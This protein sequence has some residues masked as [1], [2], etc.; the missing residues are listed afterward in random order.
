M[1]ETT[2]SPSNTISVAVLFDGGFFLKRHPRVYSASIQSGRQ[3][4]ENLYRMALAHADKKYLYRIFYY[5]CLPFEKRIHHP[6]TNRLIDFSKSSIAT[7]R[8]EVIDELKKKR[9]VALRISKL[10][11]KR[12]WLIRPQQTKD[13]L[14]GKKQI[15]DLSENDVYYELVQKGVDIKIGVD[16]ASLA[17][18]KLVNQIVLVS[19]DSDFVPAA[20]LARRQG[21]DFI[22]DPMWGNVE[23]NLYEHID[24]LVSKSPRPIPPNA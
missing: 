12:N 10:K 19:G 21:I 18:Q 5:D 11:E 1:E 14:K 4:V 9:K 17:F 6:L 16:I 15:S 13:L 24:G 23:P 7:Q 2:L 8:N 3:I 22:L 20:K